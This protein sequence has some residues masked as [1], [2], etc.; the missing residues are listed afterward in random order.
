M[1]LFGYYTTRASKRQTGKENPM[2]E[3]KKK[4][5]LVYPV[6]EIFPGASGLISVDPMGSYTGIPIVDEEPVQDA[7]DL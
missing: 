5:K 2:K 1:L 4:H 7:D 6:P 3:H